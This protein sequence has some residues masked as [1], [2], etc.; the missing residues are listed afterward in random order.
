MSGRVS[1][2]PIAV[3]GKQALNRAIPLAG[4]NGFGAETGLQDC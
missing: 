3:E 2:T 4:V 1:D